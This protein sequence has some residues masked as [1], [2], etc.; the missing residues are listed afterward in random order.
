MFA[1]ITGLL[2]PVAA[3]A[4]VSSAPSVWTQVAGPPGAVAAGPI[5]HLIFIIQENRSFDHYFGTYP[6]ADGFPSPLPCLPDNWYPSQC[7]QPY[8]NHVDSNEG[9]PHGNKWQEISIDGGKMDG[10]VNAREQFLGS[11]CKGAKNRGRTLPG[12]YEDEGIVNAK[13]CIIDVMGYHDGTDIP[14]YWAYA[15]HY[16]LYDHFFEPVISWSQP[17]HLAIFS[18]WSAKC[19]QL[20]PPDIDSC[21]NSW[22]GNFWNAKDPEPSLWTDITYMLHWNFVSWG[23]YLDG[24]QGGTFSHDSVPAIWNVLPGFETVNDDGELANTQLNLTQFFSDAAAGTLPQ[25]SWILPHY[26]DSDHPQASVRQGETYVTGLVNA[27]MKGPDW[28]SSAIFVEWDDPDGFYDHEPPP[29]QFDQ[30]GLGIRVPALLISPYALRGYVDHQVCSSDCFLKLIEDIF[31]KGVR[32]KDSG[33]PDPR[34]DYRDSQPAY[35]DLRLDFDYG[36]TNP[37]LILSTHPMSLLH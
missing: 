8:L 4:A 14:N 1:L 19:T 2:T 31:M 17:N 6:G 25:V 22:G 5:K 28:S 36:Q 21:A 11:R 29:F 26:A 35:G 10:F 27:I 16:V 24:G 33:R 13:H 20:D 23:V 34:P 9:N 3:P 7:D 37:Q 12:T 18:G 30:L 32:M 15:S